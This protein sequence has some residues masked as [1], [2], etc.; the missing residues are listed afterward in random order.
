[1]NIFDRAKAMALACPS[2][3]TWREQLRI[4]ASRRRR[5]GKTRIKADPAVQLEPTPRYA[6]MD[7]KDL[8]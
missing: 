7:R 6:W 8:L 2:P 3:T 5:Y 1:M 4:L